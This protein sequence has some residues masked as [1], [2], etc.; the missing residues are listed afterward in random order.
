MEHYLANDYEDAVV[1]VMDNGDRY[2]K[3]A[4]KDEFKAHPESKIAN[5]SIE[6]DL[7]EITKKEY[8]TFGILWKFGDG[9]RNKIIIS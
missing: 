7:F 1:R 3:F 4:G 9:F 8:E 5:G 6:C 2:V